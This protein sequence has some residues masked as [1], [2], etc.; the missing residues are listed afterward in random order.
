MAPSKIHSSW[1]QHVYGV[2]GQFADKPIRGLVNSRG[3]ST[4]GLCR[5]V[6]IKCSNFDCV[7]LK[8]DFQ[9]QMPN[10]PTYSVQAAVLCSSTNSLCSSP[11]KAAVVDL[12]K[13]CVLIAVKIN[14]A[15][16]V[17]AAR[18]WISAAASP[19]CLVDRLI[20]AGTENLTAFKI[21]SLTL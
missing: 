19:G 2:T 12:R 16:P 6:W 9:L 11:R 18:A 4:R 20:S 8:H 17:A 7:N 14:R 1:S 10:F 5:N 3:W 13:V 15:F 21:I